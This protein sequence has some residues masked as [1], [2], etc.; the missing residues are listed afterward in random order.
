M[1]DQDKQEATAVAEGAEPAGAE[2]TPE[3]YSIGVEKIDN[4]VYKIDAGVRKIS[5]ELHKPV[6]LEEDPNRV[7]TG[8]KPLDNT[9]Y[10]IDAGVRGISK[11]IRQVVDKKK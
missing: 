9:V 1:D 2:P 4:M 10:K 5:H 7:A 8:I 3:R 6:E 11:G